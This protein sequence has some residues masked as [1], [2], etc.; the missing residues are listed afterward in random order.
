MTMN[1]MGCSNRKGASIPPCVLLLQLQGVC[2]I[3]ELG[4]ACIAIWSNTLEAVE[5]TD[6]IQHTIL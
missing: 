4:S 5:E 6:V 1:V 3:C 2:S